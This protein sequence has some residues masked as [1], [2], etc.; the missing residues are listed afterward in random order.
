MAFVF[1]QS[2]PLETPLRAAIGDWYRFD[3][4]EAVARILAAAKIP[5]EARRRI[6]ETAQRL[7]EAVR[8]ERHG[9]GGIDA[10]LSEYALSSQ[11]GVALMCLAEALLRIP[12]AETADRLIRDKIGTADWELHLGHSGSLFV[13]ASTWALMLTGRLLR[14]D[15]DRDLRGVWHRFVARSG[16]PVVRQA[17]TAGMRILARQFVMG[18]TIEEALERARPA[19]RH[20]YRHSYDML[21]EAARTAAD[22]ARYFTAYETAIAA[23][24]RVADGR[25]IEDAPGISIKLSALHPRYEMVQRERV[26]AEL[27]PRLLALAQH[28]RAAGIGFTIDAEEADRLDLSLD[29]VEALALAP[30][31]G[32]WDGLGLAVQAYQKRAL[33]LT[34]WLV[35]LAARGRRRLMVRLVK[36]AYWDTEIKRAQERGLDFY[37]VYTRKVATD[38][39]Y[40]A[41]AQKLLA[42]GSALYP[43]FATHNAHTVAAVLEFAGARADWEFQRLHGMGEALY[44]QIVEPI[45]RPCRIYA[46]VGSHEDLLAYLVRRLLENGANT[47]FVNRLVD[48][49]QPV[50]QIVA[51][52]VARLATLPQKPHPQIR[53]PAEIYLTAR[54]NSRGLELNDVRVLAEL[55][56]QLEEAA[57]QPWRAAPIV[58]GTEQAGAEE[59]VLDPSD[60]RRQIG[61]VAAAS[62]AAIEAAL[63]RAAAARSWDHMPVESRAAALDL[64][65][66]LYEAHRAELMALIIREGGRTISDALSELREAAD[67]LRYYAHRARADFAAPEPLPGPT[68]E[69]NEISLYGRGVFAC[70]SPWNFPLSIFTGQIV[71]ALAAGNAVIAKPAEQTPLVAAAAVRLLHEAG[72]PGDVL[73]LLPGAG[74]SVGA[75]LVADPRI[76]GVAFTGSTE[77]ARQINLTLAKRPGPIVPLIAETGGQNA[78]VVDSSA[79]AEQVVVDVLSSA[80][81]SAGQRC[82][83][84]RLLYV[85]ED[86]A[87]HLIE[88]LTGAMAELAIGNP[89]LIATDVGPVIDGPSRDALVRH[90]A[91]IAHEGRLLYQCALPP[92]TEHGTFFA[93]RVFAIDSARRLTGEVFGPILHVVRWPADRLDEVLDEIAAT[94]YGLTLGIHSRID[95]TVRHVRTRLGVGNFYVNRNMIGAVVGAQPFGGER[96]S[97]TGPKAGGPRYLYRFATE[98]T[99]SIDTT[100]AGGNASLLSLRDEG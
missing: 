86:I 37:P 14:G 20:L 80:F 58:G 98:R 29:L 99:V 31:L 27:T 74:E 36:G 8:R 42:A 68:G 11:E 46:P 89:A 63:T 50:E 13:N 75:T 88:M 100:A 83:A 82:S 92:A 55:S 17:V 93:P 64:A 62:P 5:A 21:G 94:G 10:L 26:R 60:R 3:E 47:S 72:V 52:P 71:A 70:I 44:E 56:Q 2:P 85:Q 43:Q 23:I 78:M 4:S 84:Q 28:A 9:K 57:E 54:R 61:T 48:D 7:V 73:H 81:D 69:H 67:F 15:D 97:G 45:R 32:G 90:A 95:D 77:T 87:D 25:A 65:A 91:R 41:C 30:E 24:G 49:A 16:E 51:D 59:A 96:L 33:P 76:A 1:A 40:L 39:S 19:E 18:R 6:A 22:A 38:V 34:D 12:D 79:L 66:D 53:L 35:D